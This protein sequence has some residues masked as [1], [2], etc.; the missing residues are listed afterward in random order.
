MKGLGS[1]TSVARS[2]VND[3]TDGGEPPASSAGQPADAGLVT[4]V[5]FARRFLTSRGGCRRRRG[6]CGAS[7]GH[8]GVA[9]RSACQRGG[10]CPHAHRL[11]GAGAQRRGGERDQ[12]HERQAEGGGAGGQEGADGG[13]GRRGGRALHL[14][15]GTTLPT[16]PV[17]R[18]IIH[19]S[20]VRVGT[21]VGKSSSRCRFTTPAQS[22]NM[23]V[24]LCRGPHVCRVSVG[25]V[26]R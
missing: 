1:S 20:C 7:H 3:A 17:T 4:A 15:R 19:D 8:A 2:T 24:G 14:C 23:S 12:G 16:G 21:R 11:A 26:P 18:L 22:P 6:V 13:A 9:G 5:P 10:S 25:D